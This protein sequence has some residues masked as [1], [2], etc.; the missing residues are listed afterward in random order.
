MSMLL[1]QFVPLSPSSTAKLCSLCLHLHSCPENRLISTIF[2]RFYIYELI[3]AI[4]ICLSDFLHYVWQAL[5]L[6]TSLQLTQM[7]PFYG[8]VLVHCIHVPH[9]LYSS[10]NGHLS[11]KTHPYHAWGP[12]FNLQHP[13]L[14]LNF[15]GFPGGSNSKESSCNAGDPGLILGLKRR[16][17]KGN[18]NPLQYSCLEN[19]MDKG[20]WQSTVH[21]VANSWK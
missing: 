6:S 9:L 12:V 19:P 17:G 10:A 2:S 20:A 7:Y 3:Y 8:W 13:Q 18:G 15:L 1:S 21:R 5:A 4:C 11:G 14:E 16:P